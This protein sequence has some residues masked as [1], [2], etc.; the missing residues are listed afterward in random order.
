MAMMLA[1]LNVI[2]G[3][4]KMAEAHDVLQG[5]S[6]TRCAVA[7]VFQKVNSE[8]HNL[9]LCL[10]GGKIARCLFTKKILT[11]HFPMI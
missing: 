4:M 9:S 7:C 11:N 1:S 6:A 10:L 3:E 8:S 5:T 2:Q